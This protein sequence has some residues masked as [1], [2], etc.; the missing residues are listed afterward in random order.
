MN[1]NAGHENK[2]RAGDRKLKINFV[3]PNIPTKSQVKKKH[4]R[5]IKLWFFYIKII[6]LHF[7][8]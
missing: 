1:W 7:L 3:M 5:H 4:P 6:I 8:H 2:V